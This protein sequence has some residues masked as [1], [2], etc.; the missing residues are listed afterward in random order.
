[1]I[2]DDLEEIGFYAALDEESGAAAAGAA[3]SK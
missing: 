3:G 2:A 1:M